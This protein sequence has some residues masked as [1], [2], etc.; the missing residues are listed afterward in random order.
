MNENYYRRVIVSRI[1]DGDSMIVEIDLGF[2]VKMDQAIRLARL[3]CPEIRGHE[4]IAGLFVMAEVIKWLDDRQS[5]VC[6]IHSRQFD[7]GKFGR[8]IADL[9]CGAESLNYHLIA[10]RLAWNADDN[11]ALTEPRTVQTLSL[12][13]GIKQVVRENLA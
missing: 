5:E 4:K 13:A 9:Y 7:T 1:I 10:N 3:N 12:P 8:C 6:G 2:G 11:G